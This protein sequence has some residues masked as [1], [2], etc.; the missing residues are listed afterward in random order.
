MVTEAFSL[1]FMI[2]VNLTSVG[3][4]AKVYT[5]ILFKLHLNTTSKWRDHQESIKREIAL[6]NYCSA[7]IHLTTHVWMIMKHHH[8]HFS[9]LSAPLG[10]SV[11][12]FVLL[13]LYMSALKF[14]VVANT[15]GLS[16]I[17]SAENMNPDAWK[18]LLA[19]TGSTLSANADLKMPTPLHFQ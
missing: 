16:E 7:L 6:A 2:L 11:W 8:M 18:D 12:R 17:N 13:H 14:N 10:S 19:P 15:E 9:Y 3:D 1:L 4:G 5:R